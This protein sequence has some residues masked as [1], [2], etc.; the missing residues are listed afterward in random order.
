LRDGIRLT[1]PASDEIGHYYFCFCEIINGPVLEPYTRKVIHSNSDV[2]SPGNKTKSQ[3][4]HWWSLWTKYG[5]C[6]HQNIDDYI[7]SALTVNLQY[8]PNL[9]FHV[10]NATAFSYEELEQTYLSKSIVE[11]IFQCTKSDNK[12]RLVGAG[13]LPNS[14]FDA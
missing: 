3:M 9:F 11:P 7:S 13:V 6:T 8:V 2:I 5:T 10:L 1:K 4:N 12:R 14:Q